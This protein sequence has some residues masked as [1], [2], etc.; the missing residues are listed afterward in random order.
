[1]IPVT[2]VVSL[3]SAIFWFSYAAAKNALW[4]SVSLPAFLWVIGYVG[5][6]TYVAW[7]VENAF[8]KPPVAEWGKIKVGY[9]AGAFL[10]PLFLL[11]MVFAMDHGA[12]VF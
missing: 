9:V 10:A 4:A 3:V 8:G 2:F 11:S 1:M 7:G 5:L 6:A 12:K